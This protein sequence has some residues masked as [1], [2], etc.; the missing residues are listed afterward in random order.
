MRRLLALPIA[1]LALHCQPRT[2]TPGGASE[3]TEP[4]SHATPTDGSPT[5][6]AATG[7]DA[8]TAVAESPCVVALR[9]LGAGDY[10]GWTGL[11]AACT[12]ADAAAALG[13]GG[14]DMSGSPG[15]SPT[16]YR[17]HP[18]SA[19]APYGLQVYDV[20]DRVV[21]V[22]THDAVPAR[23]LLSQLGEPEAK[24][25]SRMPGFKTMWIWASRGLTLHVDDKSGAV[26]WLYAYAPM[27][28]DEF[29]ASWMAK[30]EI[31]RTRVR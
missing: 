9:G 20:Q 8:P 16:R 13:A 12:T 15:G 1:A 6:D 26:A 25:P 11:T 2:P 17:V 30:V 21:L 7:P 14:P 10:T 22:T 24:V 5:S 3:G 29:R 4:M 23:A 28:V 27:T 18:A 19:G 31:H